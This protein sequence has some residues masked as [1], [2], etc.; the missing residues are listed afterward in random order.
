MKIKARVSPSIIL[1]ILDYSEGMDRE[2]NCNINNS[3]ATSPPS[4]HTYDVSV[5]LDI[6]MSSSSSNNNRVVVILVFQKCS[7]TKVRKEQGKCHGNNEN[8]Q[9]FS[10]H[11]FGSNIH[12]SLPKNR[13]GSRFVAAYT[14]APY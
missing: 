6:D 1:L 5:G 14:Y 7:A 13:H 2:L 12:H 10:K 4:N 8:E 9:P 11:Y 3:K